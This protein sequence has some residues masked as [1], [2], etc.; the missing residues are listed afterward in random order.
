MQSTARPLESGLGEM[1]RAW[2][3]SRRLSQLDLS[4][5]CGI[6]QRH[7]SFVESGRSRPSREMVLRIAEGMDVPLRDCNG[8]L[9]AAGYAPLYRERDLDAAEM[10]P[11][12]GALEAMLAHHEPYPAIV[13]NREWD[14]LLANRA[15]VELLTRIGDLEAMWRRSCGDGPRNVMALTLHGGGLRPYIVNLAEFAPPL[16]YRSQREA[17]A[18]QSRRLSALLAALR[19]D[20][21][22][23]DAWHSPDWSRPPPPVL[24]MV[25]RVG[26]DE[27]RLFTMIST[28]GTPQDV[29]TDELRVE[30]FFPS[31]GDSE[32]F[33]RGL[34]A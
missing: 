20:P 34:A 3:R 28:F 33:L 13:V 27:V 30:T 32:R 1:L 12:R 9:S 19:A 14:L 15:I 25:L 5:A 18:V 7:L 17:A 21:E 16:I 23:P 10:E 22:L 26:A 29:T 24:P 11:V 8:L 2:R 6:S 4:L 31:D